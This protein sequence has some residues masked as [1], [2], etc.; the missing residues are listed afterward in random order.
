M[1]PPIESL[2]SP[3][4]PTAGTIYI[5]SRDIGSAYEPHEY[6]VA[7][8]TSEPYIE[9]LRQ[10][11]EKAEEEAQIPEA[12]KKWTRSLVELGVPSEVAEDLPT[13]SLEILKATYTFK[14]SHFSITE[15]EMIDAEKAMRRE[16]MIAR[17]KS[18]QAEA[19]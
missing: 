4:L 14:K 1:F 13:P 12:R 5:L 9:R 10:Q 19:Q 18:L 16:A 6:A 7:S 8:S 2:L 15:V 3:D 11:L 17:S